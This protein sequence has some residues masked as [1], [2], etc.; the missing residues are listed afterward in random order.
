MLQFTDLLEKAGFVPSQVRLLRHQTKAPT[1]R[2]PYI[3]WRDQRPSFEEYQSVQTIGNRAALAAPFWASFIAPPTGGTLFAGIYSAE[4]EG[5]ADP[6][7]IGTRPP[8]C[9]NSATMRGVSGSSGV[10]AHAAGSS[11]PTARTRQSLSSAVHSRKTSFQATPTSSPTYP[12]YRVCQ[13]PGSPPFVLPA[14]S[15]F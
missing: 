6:A 3:L 12:K 2:T 9:L 7:W 1:G 8:F 15:T 11:A 5:V 13:P 14:G 10:Q 4:Q